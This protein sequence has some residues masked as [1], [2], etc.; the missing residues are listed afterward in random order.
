VEVNVAA[1]LD[2]QPNEAIRK[3]PI[4]QKPFWV[5]ERARIGNGREVLVEVVVNGIAVA[6][7]PVQA[8]GRC[9]T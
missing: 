5:L 7:K 3:R 8:D 9:I 2:A 4:L 6:R 1:L